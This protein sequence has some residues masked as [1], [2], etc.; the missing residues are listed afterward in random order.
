MYK[1]NTL[2]TWPYTIERPK[3][4]YSQIIED[5]TNVYHTIY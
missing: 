3:T 4:E 5:F 1:A 2:Y